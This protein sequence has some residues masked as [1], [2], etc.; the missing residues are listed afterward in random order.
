MIGN[1]KDKD[2]WH[3]FH[4]EFNEKS[5]KLLQKLDMWTNRYRKLDKKELLCLALS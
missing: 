2:G 5:F 3:E 1:E 4:A